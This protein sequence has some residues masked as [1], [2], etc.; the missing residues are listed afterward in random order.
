M[1]VCR[2]VTPKLRVVADSGGTDAQVACH[3]SPRPH[4]CSPRPPPRRSNVTPIA[5]HRAEDLAKMRAALKGISEEL[6]ARV[7]LE[8]RRRRRLDLRSWRARFRAAEQR[9]AARR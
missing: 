1:E 5:C 7:S 4:K 2:S 6:L 8:S 9:S 3:S